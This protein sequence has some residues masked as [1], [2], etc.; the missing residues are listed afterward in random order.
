MNQ[1]KRLGRVLEQPKVINGL[2]NGVRQ[3]YCFYCLTAKELMKD[4][5]K[6]IIDVGC[7]QGDFIDACKYVF[8]KAE[9]IAFEPCPKFYDK[10]EKEVK[11]YKFGLGNENDKLFY[12]QKEGGAGGSSFLK[13][14]E[15]WFENGGDK[16][17][18]ESKADIKRF[19][20]LNI[21]IKRP[22]YL[23]IDT[24]GFDGKVLEGFG[25]RLKEI[26]IVQIEWFFQ[27]YYENQMKLSEI[28]PMMEN[29]GFKGFVQKAVNIDNNGKP[30]YC[31]LIFFK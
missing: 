23:K 10:I 27:E 4:E 22:C 1:L 12:F 28:M 7:S 8:P 29:A 30:V 9:I 14:K 13:H 11:L 24:E 19:D 15:G 25:E 16:N 21:K 17:I 18:I 3:T 2:F 31:D 20:E 5:P 26:D 6:M